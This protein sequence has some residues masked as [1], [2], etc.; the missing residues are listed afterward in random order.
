MHAICEM[1]CSSLPSFRGRWPD[2][3]GRSQPCRRGPS[4]ENLTTMVR[5]GLKQLEVLPRQSLHVF[6]QLVVASPEGGERTRFHGIGLVFP[7]SISASICSKAAAC[8]PPGEKSCSRCSSQTSLSCRAMNAARLASSSG[9]SSFTAC[10]ILVRLTV[11]CWR[12]RG[13]RTIRLQPVER[14]LKRARPGEFGNTREPRC[15]KVA[16]ALVFWC[17]VVGRGALPCG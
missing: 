16:R 5:I 6:R 15:R 11:V 9:L 17:A 13:F 1:A 10:S 7:A 8:L 14:S 12:H 3:Y 4:S 2:R